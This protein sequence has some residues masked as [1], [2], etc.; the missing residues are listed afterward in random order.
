MTLH[1]FCTVLSKK[2][3]TWQFEN[4]IQKHYPLFLQVDNYIQVTQRTWNLNI[5]KHLTSKINHIQHYPAIC[6]C[7][8]LGFLHLKDKNM[9]YTIKLVM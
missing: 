5:L 9:F 6:L 3:I 1:F 2:N 8:Y 4:Q 7:N